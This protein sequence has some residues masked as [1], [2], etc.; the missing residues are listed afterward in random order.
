MKTLACCGDVSPRRGSDVID[1]RDTLKVSGSSMGWEVCRMVSEELSTEE[2]PPRKGG[3]LTLHHGDAQL[4]LNQ[5]LRQQGIV[6]KA[7]TL[8]CTFIP[9]DLYA[10]WRSIQEE[11]L[12]ISD[13]NYCSEG[14]TWIE[15]AEKQ[16]VFA[17]SPAKP[18]RPDV[19][20]QVQFKLG[21][22]NPASQSSKLD[23]WL[24]IQSRPEQVTLPSSLQTL[25]FGQNFNKNLERVTLPSSLQSLTC[26][27]NYA[28]NLERGTLPKSLQSLKFGKRFNLTLQEVMLPSR[29]QT[30]IFGS[31]FDQS[32]EPLCQAIFKA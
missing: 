29:L 24:R 21:R 25:T 16:G 28:Q 2:L 10:A 22:S 1:L 8:L 14:V 23:V 31:C 11:G 26:G 32:L 5:I 30:L 7:V 20:R 4:L 6:G 19:W 3:K 13:A 17:P 15:S 27:D 9:T 12:Q 18:S